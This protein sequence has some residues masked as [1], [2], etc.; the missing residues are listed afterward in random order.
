MGDNEMLTNTALLAKCA[1]TEYKALCDYDFGDGMTILHISVCRD[2]TTIIAQLADVLTEQEMVNVLNKEDKC[3]RNFV[4]YAA[5]H[6]RHEILT[7]ILSLV[8]TAGCSPLQLLLKENVYGMPASHDAVIHGNPKVVEIM[9]TSL[10]ESEERLQLVM[11]RG[12]F[13]STLFDYAVNDN[14]TRIVRLLAKFLTADQLYQLLKSVDDEI[15][16]A[17]TYLHDIISFVNT[18]TVKALLDPLTDEMRVNLLDMEAIHIDYCTIKEKAV[19]KWN[20]EVADLLDEISTESMI[21]MVKTSTHKEGR[22]FNVNVV[23]TEIPTFMK[24]RSKQVL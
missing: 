17:A 19:F 12:G 9:L 18:D 7:D 20:I 16:S 8:R 24:N 15:F 5:K 3:H 2:Q 10:T 13:L 11:S 1:S 21:G 4:H 23:N 6:N 22:Y 14:N